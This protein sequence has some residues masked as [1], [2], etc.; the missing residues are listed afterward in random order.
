MRLNS[1]VL[2][3]A[4]IVVLA[5]ALLS[6]ALAFTVGTEKRSNVV[7]SFSG[8][9]SSICAA[10]SIG[11]HCITLPSHVSEVVVEESLIDKKLTIRVT[12]NSDR[13]Y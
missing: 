9:V 11:D 3:K 7:H 13:C 12:P 2:A 4:V 1:N 8:C 6:L 5:V 10:G